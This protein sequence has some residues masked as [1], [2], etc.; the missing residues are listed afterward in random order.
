MKFCLLH[1]WEYID[2]YNS[3][4]MF[5]ELIA[6]LTIECIIKGIKTPNTELI[7]YKNNNIFVYKRKC[8]KCN[9]IQDTLTPFIN[10]TINKFKKR[11]E[12]EN[13]I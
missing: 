12:F 3:L 6:Y 9:K 2:K 1:K 10:E 4:I 7:K 11:Q 8:L 13:S 5:C